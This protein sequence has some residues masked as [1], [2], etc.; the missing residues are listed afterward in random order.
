M[1][2]YSLKELEELALPVF[3]QYLNEPYLWATTDG[4]FF[5][6]SKE[7]AANL[8]CASAGVSKHKIVPPSQPLPVGEGAMEN[9]LDIE[10]DLKAMSPENLKR[11]QESNFRERAYWIGECESVEEIEFYMQDEESKTVKAAAEKRI[12]ELTA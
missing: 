6:S 10:D 8:H 11:Y 3:E 2:N 1:K 7:N 4:Q 9:E 12:E 5:L